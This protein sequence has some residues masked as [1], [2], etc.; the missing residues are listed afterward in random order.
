VLLEA[1]FASQSSLVLLPIPDVF[2]W[3][4]RI[5]NPATTGGENWTFRLPWPSDR[6]DEVVEARERREALRS[7]ARR[8]GRSRAEP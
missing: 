2:G 5:N 3:P 8:H 4:D 7:W 1:L 6:L